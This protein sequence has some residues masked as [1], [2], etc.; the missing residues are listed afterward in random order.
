M[1]AVPTSVLLFI[2]Y[3]FSLLLWFL[4][5]GICMDINWAV[6]CQNC[7]YFTWEK[8]CSSKSSRYFCI[9]FC[10]SSKPST[11]CGVISTVT[12]SGSP[13]VPCVLWSDTCS[14]SPHRSLSEPLMTYDLHRDLMCAA[15]KKCFWNKTSQF[16]PLFWPLSLSSVWVR[17][18]HTFPTVASLQVVLE[19]V[20]CLFVKIS[21]KLKPTSDNR[22]T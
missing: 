4:F 5:F 9:W 11:V 18:F 14:L 15:S 21:D 17:P 6:S 16:L 1:Y 7:S 19:G 3:L 2:I 22:F 12:S 10:I 13:C 8:F 20:L